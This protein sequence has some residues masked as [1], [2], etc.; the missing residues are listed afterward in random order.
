MESL[1]LFA[2]ILMIICSLVAIHEVGHYL[3]GLTAGIPASDMRIILLA[4]PQHVVLRDGTEW[5]SPIRDIVRYVEV[6]RRYFATRWAAFRYVA[7]GIAV[8]T[9]FTVAVCLIAIQV[10]WQAI[11]FWVASMSLGMYLVNLLLLDL[12]WAVVHR[13]SVGDTSGLWEIAPLPAVILTVIA[14]AIRVVLIVSTA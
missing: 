14:L 11:A 7:G 2:L 1:L 3:A 9:V 4:F 5:V 6:S 12:P 10:G 13:R 8:E